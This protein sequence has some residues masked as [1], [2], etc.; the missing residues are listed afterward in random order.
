MTIE[1]SGTIGVNGV[2]TGG[3]NARNQIGAEVGDTAQ[4]ALNLNCST[5]RTLASKTSGTIHMSDFY[6]KG[7][8]HTVSYVFNS[9]NVASAAVDISS[10]S[11]PSG[12]YKCGCYVSGKS[13][14]FVT[15]NSGVL[16]YGCASG[17]AGLTITGGA[18]GDH[19]KIINNGTIMGRG[20]D[21]GR[22]TWNPYTNIGQVY[23]GVPGA[24]GLCYSGLNAGVTID[25]I[26][27]NGWIVG[28]GGGGAG[29][30][31][32]C[33]QGCSC[34]SNVCCYKAAIGG[35]GGAG[36]GNGGTADCTDVFYNGGAGGTARTA[37][38]DSPSNTPPGYV[39]YYGHGGGGGGRVIPPCSATKGRA[40]ILYPGPCSVVKAGGG[41]AGGS[42]GSSAW[43]WRASPSYF[44]GIALIGACGG[45]A[46][47]AAKNWG[48][49]YNCCA[50]YSRS[51]RGAGGG[52]GYG[53][54]GGYA[55]GF[56]CACYVQGGTGGAAV[57]SNGTV[58]WKCGATGNIY[59]SVS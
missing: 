43:V 59:G 11:A 19:L 45:A 2:C 31:I 50:C 4:T 36:G 30:F 1:S 39:G 34:S 18:S 37:G 24:T 57:K 33:T 32:C 14:V 41:G 54:H 42:G 25:Y 23:P 7:S 8:R 3:S 47:G 35:G 46:G 10:N 13:C 58:V 44:V 40:Y 20:G 6:G 55:P 22:A 51:I 9:T 5:L 53:A 28:G 52:G 56:D 12:G 16:L 29:T 15:V 38:S 21:G 48:Q 49:Y 27:N 26:Q 17:S